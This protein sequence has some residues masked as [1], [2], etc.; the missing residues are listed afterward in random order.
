MLRL[1]EKK[2]PKILFLHPFPYD[3]NFWKYQFDLKNE[4]YCIFPDLLGAGE[5][6]SETLFT[7]EEMCLDI[8]NEVEEDRIHLVGL[9]MGGYVAQRMFEIAPQK[10]QSLILMDT[11]SDSDSNENKKKRALDIQKLKKV[12]LR[13]YV[14]NTV[15]N[16]VSIKTKNERKDK[17]EFLIDISEKQNSNGIISE[18]LAM[19][20]RLDMNSF[21]EKIQKPTLI[22]VGAEDKITPK[23]TMQELHKKIQGSEFHV[24]ENAGH[25]SAVEDADRINLILKNFVNTNE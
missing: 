16:A 8:L 9:S 12:N 1:G 14:L 10:F 20:G 17:L 13:E 21:I 18:L 4:Y 7:L 15:E 11:K 25:L 6:G 22:I 24:I 2:N 5:K 23:E 3:K 19:Q